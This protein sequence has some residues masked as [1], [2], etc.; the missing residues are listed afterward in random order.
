MGRI[1]ELFLSV[2]GRDSF[3]DFFLN[4]GLFIKIYIHSFG[5]Y[6]SPASCVFWM[7]LRRGAGDKSLFI[8]FSNLL[9]ALTAFV[10]RVYP[11]HEFSFQTEGRMAV[12]RKRTDGRRTKGSTR[13]YRPS[14]DLSLLGA[15]YSIVAEEKLLPYLVSPDEVRADWAGYFL[16]RRQLVLYH[17]LRFVCHEYSFWITLEANVHAMGVAHG[18]VTFRC[19]RH[20]GQSLC[21]FWCDCFDHAAG[22]WAHLDQH[23][24]FGVACPDLLT[25]AVRHCGTLSTAERALSDAQAFALIRDLLAVIRRAAQQKTLAPH[26]Q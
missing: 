20:E 13:L 23:P 12:K 24:E 8:R 9:R 26:I 5:P 19:W 10:L 2:K 18:K 3:R 16:E 21:V 25:A 6:L 1:P 4:I 22:F 7:M 11:L 14:L 15:L 17:D